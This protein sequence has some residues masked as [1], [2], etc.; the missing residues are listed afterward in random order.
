MPEF[1]DFLWRLLENVLVAVLP[2]LATTLTVWLI[3]KIRAIGGDINENTMY[4]IRAA[5]NIAVTAA[6]QAG[7]AGLIEDKKAY[8]LE[9]AQSYLGKQKIKI[10]LVL[11]D[12][13]IESAVKTAIND[14]E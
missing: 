10:D 9:L 13:I 11:L 14:E 3:Q 1:I 4:A 5:V 2:I 6:E 7:V 12:G 8:A